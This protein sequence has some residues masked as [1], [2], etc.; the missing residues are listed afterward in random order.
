MTTNFV[1]LHNHFLLLTTGSW[2][3][4]R[5]T[6]SGEAL[7]VFRAGHQLTERLE[8]GLDTN[9]AKNVLNFFLEILIKFLDFF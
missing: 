5:N 9:I 1:R 2:G 6:A 7:A 8:V 4:A 3:A